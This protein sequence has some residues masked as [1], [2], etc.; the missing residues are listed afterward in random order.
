MKQEMNMD[1][2]KKLLQ[3]LLQFQILCFVQTLCSASKTH[4]SL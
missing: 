3:G 1:H 2:E 4:S